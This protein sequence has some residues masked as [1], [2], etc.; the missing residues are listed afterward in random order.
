[1]I[2]R[3]NTRSSQLREN[4]I[5]QETEYT[6]E[7]PNALQI[8]TAVEERYASEG[9]SLGWLRITLRGQEDYAHIGRKMQEGWQ[10]VD[11]DEVPEMG[12]TSIVR[13]EGRYKGAVCRGDLA[14]GKIPTGRIEA[15]KAH[16]KN[17]ADKLME[18]VNS[19]LMRGNNSRMPISNSSKT[20]TIRGRT[21]KFQE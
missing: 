15:R 5:K 16:Y 19:Q 3:A 11:S 7:E 9:I 12:A 14:L 2:T 13:D 21:P 4:N 8:P 17:K 10:F 20:Q 6:F 18:A 1:M